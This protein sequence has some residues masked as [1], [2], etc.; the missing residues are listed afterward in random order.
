MKLRRSLFLFVLSGATILTSCTPTENPDIVDP[1]PEPK[2]EPEVP[3][4]PVDPTPEPEP[5]PE[6][7]VVFDESDY[8]VDLLG[9]FYS[10]LGTLK[11]EPNLLTLKGEE[12]LTLKPT[13][14]EEITENNA[15]RTAVNYEDEKTGEKNT[16][17]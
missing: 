6:V 3:S 4:T 2:P 13:S 15:I 8:D 9:I 7:P 5:E 17:F 1:T 16:Q 14:I 12:E 11:I 10:R